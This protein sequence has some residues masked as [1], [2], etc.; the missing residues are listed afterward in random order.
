MPDKMDHLDAVNYRSFLG[1]LNSNL[2]SGFS[3][4]GWVGLVFYLN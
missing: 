4:L 1:A 2:N 3:I